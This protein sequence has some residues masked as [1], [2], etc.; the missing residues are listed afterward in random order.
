L[1]EGDG[2]NDNRFI[3][4]FFKCVLCRISELNICQKLE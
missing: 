4:I 3:Q 2:F 1:K